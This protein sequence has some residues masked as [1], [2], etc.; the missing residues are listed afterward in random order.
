[1]IKKATERQERKKRE[2]LGYLKR[3]TPQNAL[4]ISDWWLNRETLK[5][6]STWT[7]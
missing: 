3:T 5:E 1:M 4:R 6:Q 7:N 2:S